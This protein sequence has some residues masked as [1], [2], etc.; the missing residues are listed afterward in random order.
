MVYKHNILCVRTLTFK[1][2]AEKYFEGVMI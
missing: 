1:S 2:T